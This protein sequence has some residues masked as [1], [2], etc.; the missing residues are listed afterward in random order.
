MAEKGWNTTDAIIHERRVEL[1]YECDR[2]RDLVRWHK[3][4]YLAKKTFG[5]VITDYISHFEVGKNEYF[6][7][8]VKEIVLTEGSLTQNN[9]Y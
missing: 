4:G 2:F 6:P 1:A 8:P 3:N 9:G 7:I 5:K